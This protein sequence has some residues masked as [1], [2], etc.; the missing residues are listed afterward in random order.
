MDIHS[1]LMGQS[2]LFQQRAQSNIA[3]VNHVG[4]QNE[5]PSLQSSINSEENIDNTGTA[6]LLEGSVGIQLPTS[7]I[8]NAA[9]RHAMV[10]SYQKRE[11][12][13]EG[14]NINASDEER[15]VATKEVMRSTVL[16]KDVHNDSVVTV[17]QHQGDCSEDLS[18]SSS[19]SS[20]EGSDGEGILPLLEGFVKKCDLASIKQFQCL[21]KGETQ[22]SLLYRAI[23]H[24][25][26]SMVRYILTETAKVTMN[27][28]LLHIACR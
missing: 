4:T 7:K 11:V 15:E 21:I 12:L 3:Y 16:D 13:D 19:Q 24:K 18:K 27:L 8:N 26:I 22:K 25:Q 2:Q 28:N 5:N 23:E 1:S 17:Q 9:Q 20:M 14:E 10:K 6:S